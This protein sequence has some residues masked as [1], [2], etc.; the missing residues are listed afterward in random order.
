MKETLLKTKILQSL[1]DTPLR[2]SR[3]SFGEG[4]LDF[5]TDKK[6]EMSNVRIWDIRGHLWDHAKLSEGS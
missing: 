5:V 2:N 6:G 3:H 4:H 1:T